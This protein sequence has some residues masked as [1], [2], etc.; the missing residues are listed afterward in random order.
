MQL[1]ANNV[2]NIGRRGVVCAAKENWAGLGAD[3]A[4][5]LKGSETITK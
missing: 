5:K 3:D 4:L 2:L 1:R